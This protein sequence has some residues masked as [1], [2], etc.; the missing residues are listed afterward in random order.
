MVFEEDILIEIKRRHRKDGLHIF[1]G[2]NPIT[3][4]VAV[5]YTW[6]MISNILSEKANKDNIMFPD[7]RL[8]SMKID[9]WGINCYFE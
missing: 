7:I 2:K 9:D 5:G 8:K 4:G 3:C 1:E 6:N